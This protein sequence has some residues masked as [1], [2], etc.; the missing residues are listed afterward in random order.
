MKHSAFLSATLAVALLIGIGAGAE[1]AVFQVVG[2]GDSIMNGQGFDTGAGTPCKQ[3][4]A[5]TCGF[6][7]RLPRSKYYNCAS[8]M[9]SFA[10]RGK[11]SETTLAG[12]TRL[13]QVLS[14]RPWDLVILMEGTNDINTGVS[15]ATVQFNLAQMAARAKARNAGT[16]QSSIIWF[17]ANFN[18]SGIVPRNQAARNLRGGIASQAATERRCFVDSWLKLCPEGT[19]QASC[20]N[21]NY[22]QGGQDPVG[23]PNT[24]GY[25]ILADEFFRVLGSAGL[26]GAAEIV[27]PAGKACGKNTAIEWRKETVAGTACGNWFQVQVDGS[28]GN[29]YDEWLQEGDVCTGSD[30]RV[31]IPGGLPGGTFS[32]RIRT[33][34]TRGYGPWTANESFTIVLGAPKRIVK[35][36]GPKGDF[37]IQGGLEAELE[38]KPVSNTAGYQIEITEARRGIILD[39][40]VTGVDECE[41]NR[42]IY[43]VENPLPTGEYTWRVQAQNVCGGTWTDRT[44]FTVIDGPPAIAPVALDPTE[45]IFDQTPT[46]KWEIVEAAFEYEI[47]DAFGAST[48]VAAETACSG[49]ICRFTSAVLGPGT[50]TWRV[51]GINP[52][53]AGAWSETVSFEVANC[54][55]F[56]GRAAGGSSFLLARPTVWNGDL[57]IWNHASNYFGFKEF[58]NFPPL[59]QRQ[60]D[61]GFAIAT[62][63]YSVTGW[64]LFKSK[65]DLE[66]VYN[67][68]VAR[69]GEPNNVYLTGES[70]G[71][72]V[73]LG[74][75]E[76]ADLGNV[77]GILAMCGP[78]AGAQ[79]WEGTL[80]L[81][82]I[83]DAICGG[84]QGAAIPG[85]PKGLPK[86]HDLEPADIAAAVNLCTGV[87]DKRSNR[88]IE[89]KR[90]MRQI[91]Q[92]TGIEDDGLQEAMQ[93][94]T[95]G[96]SD[97]V[98][99]RK[100][101]KGKLPVGNEGVDY[102]LPFVNNTVQRAF[103]ETGARP[104]LD[105]FYQL[106]GETGDTKVIALHTTQ[107]PV[108]YV[109]NVREY[110]DIAPAENLTLGVIREKSSSHCGFSEVEEW[111]SFRALT[112]WATGGEQPK[113]RNL[114][115]RCNSLKSSVGGSCRF[116]K[117]P[118]IDTLDT[119]IPPRP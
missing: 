97:L 94:A 61:D 8:S 117:R 68:F 93:H 106:E 64:P 75:V 11:P 42:C 57:V 114:Q 83:Y 26:P 33:R 109:Q 52:L 110:A 96:L 29:R 17:Q 39:T 78:L 56:D 98:R 23:H 14:E 6:I 85:G 25:N 9:C 65:R 30:C 82:L 20:F 71:A 60:F 107:D 7:G 47:E 62:T 18:K 32:T 116:D 104:K 4:N 111:A 5:D 102:G 10:N 50:H 119:R 108:F 13:T 81:R 115:S 113:P 59:A 87:D 70:A 79:N 118:K 103:P 101:L 69:Y 49:G 51:R 24:A 41:G 54:D 84:V 67:T 99:D 44:A 12:L 27:S 40:V 16:A 35:T 92:I 72:L 91:T 112:L 3:T 90:R 55:C 58:D 28:G 37:F 36:F 89:Q 21:K 43:A 76:I 86:P 63:S 31:T 66:K 105:R 77:A 22:W 15:V 88:S 95:F 100:K 74:A 2:F 48:V 46:F 19:Q 53:G 45:R 34:N 1:A 73:A 38:W 80:D